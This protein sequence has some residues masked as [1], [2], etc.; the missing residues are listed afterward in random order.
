MSDLTASLIHVGRRPAGRAGERVRGGAHL[1]ELSRG[2][3]S[4]I[5]QPDLESSPESDGRCF[6]GSVQS[7]ICRRSL[8]ARASLPLRNASQM[9]EHRQ[10]H[11]GEDRLEE[12]LRNWAVMPLIS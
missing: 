1:Y 3:R 4:Q 5:I 12:R 11:G 6:A 7:G 2:L 10:G 9:M 8:D